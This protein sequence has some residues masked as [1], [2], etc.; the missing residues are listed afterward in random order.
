MQHITLA[1]SMINFIWR[2]LFMEKDEKNLYKVLFFELGIQRGVLLTLIFF[3][4]CIL[5]EGKLLYNFVMVSFI[6]QYKS[7]MCSVAKSCPTLCDLM[8]CSP[9]GWFCPWD[10]LGKNTG[11]GSHFL[12]Q[13][14]SRN[15]TYITSPLS[16]PPF[17][18]PT[19]PGHHR[20][21]GF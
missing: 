20:V 15:Y 10:F 7:A 2:V 14:I 17:P 5:I 3:L 1:Y 11:V 21:P 16:L 18:H 13:Q 4:I 12:L 8:D 19:P 6:Q 9:P